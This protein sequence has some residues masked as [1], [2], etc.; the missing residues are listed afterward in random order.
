MNQ[1]T[2]SRTS[3]RTLGVPRSTSFCQILFVSLRVILEVIKRPFLPKPT[4]KENCDKTPTNFAGAAQ[5]TALSL[6][7]QQPRVRFS[8]SALRFID[9]AAA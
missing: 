9:S 2:R 3:P 5:W 4:R 8:A 6:F 7:N 1:K